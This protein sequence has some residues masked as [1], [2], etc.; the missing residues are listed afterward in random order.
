MDPL[1]EYLDARELSRDDFGQRH[2]Y[3]FLV[4]DVP[5]GILEKSSRFATQMVSGIGRRKH[6]ARLAQLEREGKELK[7]GVEHCLVFRVRKRAASPFAEIVS[8]G[9]TAQ[10]DICIPDRRI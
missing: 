1:T 9:R 10:S 3:P 7:S 6:L 8:V 4:M 5:R 2:E